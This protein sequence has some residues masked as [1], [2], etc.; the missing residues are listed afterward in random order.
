MYT[1]Q[2]VKMTSEFRPEH[3]VTQDYNRW[4]RN[5][6]VVCPASGITL[7]NNSAISDPL[8][9][10]WRGTRPDRFWSVL[11]LTQV[12]N[13]VWHSTLPLSG[14]IYVLWRACSLTTFTQFHW[15]SGPPVCFQSWGTRVQSP[16]GYFCKTGILLLALACYIGDP[17]SLWPHLRRASSRT[18]TRRLCWQC[19]NPTWSHRALLSRFRTH[20]SSFWLHN[21]HSRLLGGA[22][23]RACNLSTFTQFHWSS[24][25]PICFLSWGTRVQS[26]GGYLCETRILLLVLPHY[27]M[28]I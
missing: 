24:G 27:S 25:P 5:L 19:D 11:R 28:Y 6:P 26:P 17:L 7:A 23:W 22:L 20:W 3:R 12:C 15:S 13:S 10:A 9:N 18:A 14:Y 1:V 4:F 8:A 21:R 16:G 2:T